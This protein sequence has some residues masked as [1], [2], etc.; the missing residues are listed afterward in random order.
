MVT[1]F[2]DQS[3]IAEG[4]QARKLGLRCLDLE[5]MRIKCTS[6]AGGLRIDALPNSSVL[7]ASGLRDG[8]VLAQFGPERLPTSDSF[9][10]ALRRYL[11]DRESRTLRVHRRGTELEIK[12][13]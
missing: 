3:F 13:S 7:F 4:A 10:A 11:V 9:R 8:D 6:V 2:S 5:K 12:L 1:D